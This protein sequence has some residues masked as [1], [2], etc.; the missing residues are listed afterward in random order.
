MLNEAETL[1]LA[2]QKLL[3]VMVFFFK[4]NGIVFVQAFI[5]EVYLAQAGS[6]WACNPGLIWHVTW[7][8]I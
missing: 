2:T 3:M 5:W 6:K 7:A 1:F 4:L 8:K